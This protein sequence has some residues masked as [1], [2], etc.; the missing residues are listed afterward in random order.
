MEADELVW[1]SHCPR[2]GTERIREDLD[3]RKL[4]SGGEE[5]WLEYDVTN[6]KTDI[7]PGS[8]EEALL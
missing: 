8:L 6:D 4:L 2:L 1:H 5:R 3:T 7:C